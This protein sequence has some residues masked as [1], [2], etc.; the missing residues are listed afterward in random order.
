MTYR[1]ISLLALFQRK[2][3]L[4]GIHLAT[5]DPS[6]ETDDDKSIIE[7][8]SALQE[9]FQ[10]YNLGLVACELV[11]KINS[12]GWIGSSITNSKNYLELSDY[13]SVIPDQ[14]ILTPLGKRYYS[15]MSLSEISNADLLEFAETLSS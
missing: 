8:I 3:D 12:D 9:I 15:I 11:E 7:D 14:M 5:S 4:E 2:T 1:Q 10:L 13:D 6:I